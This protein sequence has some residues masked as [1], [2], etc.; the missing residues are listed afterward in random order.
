MS[1]GLEMENRFN[2][3]TPGN[4]SN[5]PTDLD[6][7]YINIFQKLGQLEGVLIT[8]EKQINNLNLEHTTLEKEVNSSMRELKETT[9]NIQKSI[10]IMLALEKDRR[11]NLRERKEDKKTTISYIPVTIGILG[12]IIGIITGLWEFFTHLNR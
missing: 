8:Q 2:P 7:R 9:N 4:N 3:S 1:M 11:E 12:F 5:P 10:D 6:P